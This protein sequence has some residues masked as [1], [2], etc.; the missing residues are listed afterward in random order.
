MSL[1]ALVKTYQYNVNQQ[2]LATGTA[3]GTNR[4]MVKLI[5]D[6][7]KGFGTLPWVTQ[8]S[9]DGTVL[10]TGT[11][12]DGADRWTLPSHLVWNTAGS[13]H[14]WY[15]LRRND[16]AELLIECA[17]SNAGGAVLSLYLSPSAHFSGGTN[18]A[19]PTATDEIQLLANGAI[20]LPSTDANLRLHVWHSTDAQ[21]T[22][23]VVCN[24]GFATGLITIASPQ[25]PVSGWTNPIW[26][27]SVGTSGVSNALTATNLNSN[28]NA[29]GRVTATMDLY[30]TSEGRNN[31]ML[32]IASLVANDL[33]S[34]W[35]LYPI[36][37]YSETASHRGR[38]GTVFDLWF[39]SDGISTGDTYPN[40]ATRT[41]I[42]LGQLVFP[43]NGSVPVLT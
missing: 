36:G 15:V 28:A 21:I 12:G 20:G 2:V 22:H 33:T 19:R 5:K 8:Y 17:N 9:S 37:L 7:L 18:T 35:P 14:S 24:G 3:L 30:L 43:W 26:G 39:G 31:S 23:I 34:E 11:A 4:T 16:G 38:H 1:P 42:Q 25:S 6:T 40:D 10:G 29:K 13:A 41:F 32:H 27:L